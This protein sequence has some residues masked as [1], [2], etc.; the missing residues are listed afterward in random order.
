LLSIELSDKMAILLVFCAVLCLYI[1]CHTIYTNLVGP[2]KNAPPGKVTSDLK[3]TTSLVIV[4][5]LF[6]QTIIF[7]SHD[8]ARQ[9]TD[10]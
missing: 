5:G 4:K 7:V 3:H 9:A 2:W 6:T 1:L 8:T 10:R